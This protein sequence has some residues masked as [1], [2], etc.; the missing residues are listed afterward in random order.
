[1]GWRFTTD[2]PIYAQI[3]DHIQRDI[4]AGT[5]P[6]GSSMP[7]VRALALEAEVNPNTM[8]KALA[9]LEAQ[10]LLHTHRASGRT[11][12]SDE[13]LISELRISTARML[14]ERYFTDMQALGIGRDEARRMLSENVGA[15]AHETSAEVM[16]TQ[17]SANEDKEAVE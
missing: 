3:V 10:A 17:T 7:S 5:Y 16:P 8:Q 2:R 9:E 15:F 1:M 4:L 12:T 11:V 14:V 6:P 13:S